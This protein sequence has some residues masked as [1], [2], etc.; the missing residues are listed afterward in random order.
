[1][2]VKCV[3][4]ALWSDLRTVSRHRVFTPHTQLCSLCRGVLRWVGCVMM[5]SQSVHCPNITV[6]TSL[7]PF[8]HPSAAYL[9]PSSAPACSC[10]APPA[11]VR[12]L[13]EVTTRGV[14]ETLILRS[15]HG[16]QHYLQSCLAG[17]LRPLGRLCKH[18]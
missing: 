2:R 13:L 12:Y 1:M 14:S 15:R 18:R 8:S 4:I 7:H 3:Q 9:F 6:P 17:T 5:C 16:S 11:R 10:P